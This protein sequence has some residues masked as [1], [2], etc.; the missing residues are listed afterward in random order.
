M[1]SPNVL[2]ALDKCIEYLEQII[3]EEREEER[4][5]LAKDFEQY[6][7][8]KDQEDKE[9]TRAYVKTLAL[10]EPLN[11][12]LLEFIEGFPVMPIISLKSKNQVVL[13]WNCAFPKQKSLYIELDGKCNLAGF[14]WIGE[15]SSSVETEDIPGLVRDF[16]S[17]EEEAE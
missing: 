17:K 14:T 6:C 13:E 2:N 7:R 16:F 1:T 10:E 12:T 3:D 9:N 4:E 11:A 8:E 15:F 5:Q